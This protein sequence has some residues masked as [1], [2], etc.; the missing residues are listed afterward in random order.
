[1]FR[2]KRQ[3]VSFIEILFESYKSLPQSFDY[4]IFNIEPT[5]LCTE[6]GH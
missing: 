4:F 1:M 3:K 6:K 2:V 5:G